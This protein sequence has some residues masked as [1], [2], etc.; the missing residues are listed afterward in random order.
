ME[1]S[2]K[3]RQLNRA[4][5]AVRTE[6][7]RGSNSKRGNEAICSLAARLMIV[8][9]DGLLAAH[10]YSPSSGRSLRVCCTLAKCNDPFDS[11]DLQN[12]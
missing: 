5:S 10:W 8:P 12:K 6:T 3:T 2:I 11:S 9:T 1:N 4:V 7:S